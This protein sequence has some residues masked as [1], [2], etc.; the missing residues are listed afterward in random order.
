MVGFPQSEML[1]NGPDDETLEIL[2][3]WVR[4]KG[5]SQSEMLR[6]GMRR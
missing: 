6:R 4:M 2:K 1:R 3:A 5:P